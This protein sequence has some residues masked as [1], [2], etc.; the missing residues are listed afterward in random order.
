MLPLHNTY[1]DMPTDFVEVCYLPRGLPQIIAI[2]YAL[3]GYLHAA[4]RALFQKKQTDS[5]E[6]R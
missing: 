4:S 1:L 2:C 6:T 5:L 3:P